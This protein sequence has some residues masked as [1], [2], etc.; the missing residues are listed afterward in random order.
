[1]TGLV[2]A[3]LGATGVF[4][5]LTATP[6]FTATSP[7]AGDPVVGAMHDPGQPD[8]PAWREARR[9]WGIWCG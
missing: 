1:M 6:T 4:L 3:V 9:A 7:A 2:L 8:E 5:L